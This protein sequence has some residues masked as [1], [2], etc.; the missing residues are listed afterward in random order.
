MSLTQSLPYSLSEPGPTDIDGVGNYVVEVLAPGGSHHSAISIY[1]LDTHAYSPDEQQF[2]GY[3]WLKKNQVEW[4]TKTSESLKKPHSEY[5]HI[6]MD[7]AFIHIPLPEYR[8]KGNIIVGSWKEASTAPA[9]NS[10]FKDALVKQG[11]KVVSCGQYVLPFYPF[12]SRTLET[13]HKLTSPLQRP[14]KRLLHA[15]QIRQ[16]Q[17]HTLDVLR[18]RLR[19]WWLWR[20]WWLS[21][22]RPVLRH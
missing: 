12:Y 6:H 20:I 10:G 8:E 5:T 19:V 11:V 14:C 9:F 1:L 15:R 3:D 18:R 7:M 21:S 13:Y 17:A 2:R 4:F 22:S 16:Q